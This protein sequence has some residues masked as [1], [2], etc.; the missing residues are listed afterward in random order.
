MHKIIIYSTPSCH[1]CH[2]AKD[3][4]KSINVPFE[5]INVA[6]NIDKQKE[7]VAKSGQFGVPVIIIDD[8]IV[9]GFDRPKIDKLL[10]Q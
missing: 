2:M 1:F 7:L 6:G 4:F 5:E 9:V 10:R 8:K 3:Y